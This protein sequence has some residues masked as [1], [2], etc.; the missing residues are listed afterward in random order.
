M[1]EDSHRFACILHLVVGLFIEM[2]LLPSTS[3]AEYELP[4]DLIVDMKDAVKRL[5]LGNKKL[6]G[7]I[8][9]RFVGAKRKMTSLQFLL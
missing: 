9:E 6:E 2:L 4:D 3:L 1:M 8:L 7:E 5:L